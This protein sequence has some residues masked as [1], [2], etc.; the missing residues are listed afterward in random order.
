MNLLLMEIDN[1]R[2]CKINEFPEFYNLENQQINQIFSDLKK[3]NWFQKFAN[4][5]IV[6]SF[7]IPHYS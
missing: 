3:N 5:G 2:I 1:F 7:D 6:R 4:F